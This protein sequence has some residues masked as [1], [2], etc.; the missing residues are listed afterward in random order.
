MGNSIFLVKYLYI[1]RSSGRLNWYCGTE[2]TWNENCCFTKLYKKSASS[3]EMKKKICNSL[4]QNRNVRDQHV[5][6]KLSVT[7]HN[8]KI[9]N[10]P[11]ALCTVSV[12]CSRGG[13]WD[14]TKTVLHV[15]L[16]SSLSLSLSLLPSQCSDHFTKTYLSGP[17]SRQSWTQSWTFSGHWTTPHQ[18]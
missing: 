18:Q 17:E 5:V 13:G 15:I 8:Y 6:V 1:L 4:S 16:R 7:S 14:K 9:V 10:Q 12:V 2:K 3:S 11:S